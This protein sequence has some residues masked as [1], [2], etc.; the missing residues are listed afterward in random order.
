MKRTTISM[1]ALA[2]CSTLLAGNLF[3]QSD[4]LPARCKKN[5]IGVNIGPL[6]LVALGA[7]PYA[8]AFGI[9][10]KRVYGKW[11]LRT[12]LSFVPPLNLIT[13]NYTERK[14][15]NDS[16]YSH[17]TTFNRN[18][19]Y[20]GRLGLEYR[21]TF[22]NGWSFVIGGD[23]LGHYAVNNRYI[24]NSV[25]KVDSI[26]GAGTANPTIF[27]SQKEQKKLLDEDITR[28]QMGIGLTVGLIVPFNKHWCAQAQYRIDAMAGPQKK[29]TND[30]VAGK[31][32]RSNNTVFDFSSGAAVSELSLF[33]RF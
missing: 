10:Y 4:T 18:R 23:L 22:K 24:L 20:T 21:N 9:T 6:V 31:T 14:L 26:K 33:Y 3:S 5:E 17:Q 8:Q 19:N 7:E 13:E 12:N 11:A 15:F 29:T 30:F 16:I 1:V 2:T 28:T 25:F 27:A 32:T